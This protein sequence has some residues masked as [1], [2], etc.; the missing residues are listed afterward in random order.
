MARSDETSSKT[1]YI[2]QTY[3]GATA[4]STQGGLK[5]DK[6][7]EY[8]TASAAEERAERECRLQNC[9]GADAY[10]L[11]EDTD[12]GEVSLPVFLA[13][14]GMVPEVDAF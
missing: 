4:G 11:I 5:V 8:S 1:H 7:I 10:M 14:H 9:I 3:L 12:S 2:C 13:R 6:L